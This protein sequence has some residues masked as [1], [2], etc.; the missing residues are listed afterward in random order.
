MQNMDFYNGNNF[1]EPEKSFGRQDPEYFARMTKFH[2]KEDNRMRKKASRIIFIIAALCIISF[3]TG[4]AIGIKF[5]GGKE[6]QIVDEKTFNA[7]KG[8]GTK[9][10]GMFNRKNSEKFTTEQFP[11]D[12]YPYVIKVGASYDY[13]DSQKIANFLSVNGHTVII[14]KNNNRYSLFTGPYRNQDKAEN[15]LKKFNSYNQFSLASAAK[16]LKRK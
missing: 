14:S 8:I 11:R 1:H 16:I 13:S 4:L 2:A 10:S 7:V 6:R 5:A 12:K 3:T 9:V 15:I